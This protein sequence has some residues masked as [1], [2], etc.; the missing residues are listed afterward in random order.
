MA[1]VSVII[2]TYNRFLQ[3]CCAVESVLKQTYENVEIIVVDDGSTDQTPSAF[4][5]RF[6]S[7][8]YIRIE[9]SGLPSVAR[10]TGVRLAKGA[11]V[12]FLDSDDQWQSEKLAQQ[13]AVL[14]AHPNIGLAC[15]NAFVVQGNGERSDKRCPAPEIGTRKHALETLLHDNFVIAS[16]AVVR[17]AV[18]DRVGL[19][20]ETPVLRAV[21]DYDLWLRIAAVSEVFYDPTALALYRDDPTQSIRGGIPPLRQWESRLLIL[22]RF[23]QAL[24]IAHRA[25][26]GIERAIAFQENAF[27]KLRLDALL[28]EQRYLSAIAQAATLCVKN[29]ERVVKAFARRVGCLLQGSH[30]SERILVERPDNESVPGTGLKLHLGCGETYFPGYLNIDSPSSQHTVQRTSKADLYADLRQLEYPTASVQEIRSHHVFE[31]FD[32]VTALRLLMDWYGWLKSGG[33]VVIETPD[34]RR[35]AEEF[36]RSNSPAEQHK[37]I[38]HLFGSQEASWAVHYDGWH[39]DKFQSTLTALGF[40][41]LRFSY[42]EWQGTY[43]ITVR[44]SKYE[45]FMPRQEQERAAE[46]ILRTYLVNDSDTEQQMLKVWTAQLVVRRSDQWCSEGL[47]AEH[48][49]GRTGGSQ[50]R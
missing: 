11:Y 32:R 25:D 48:S 17:R 9:H 23:R 21:E 39:Q 33:Q 30:E 45:P 50:G 18:L 26:P 43:N 15:S 40:Q 36:V 38:R 24:R 27:G 44:A 31:H 6:P 35:C 34:F 3:L 19:F 20:E 42:S 5:Q 47:E 8:Q 2:P 16:T 46:S 22:A 10:N 7:V 41:D 4:P 37:L 14:D 12:A 49:G 28:A 1:C 29:P 13:V